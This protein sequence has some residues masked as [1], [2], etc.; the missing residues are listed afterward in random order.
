MEKETELKKPA[1][2]KDEALAEVSGGFLYINEEGALEVID[3]N[4]NVVATYTGPNAKRDA[5]QKCAE[6]GLSIKFIDYGDLEALRNKPDY[7]VVEG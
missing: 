7:I 3:G 1:V 5:H 2:L 4:G 6:L